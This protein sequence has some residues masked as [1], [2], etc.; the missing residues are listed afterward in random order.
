MDI[1]FKLRYSETQGSTSKCDTVEKE[2]WNL[3][4]SGNWRGRLAEVVGPGNLEGLISYIQFA[5]KAQRH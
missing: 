4:E 2:I 3:P 1:F 5:T